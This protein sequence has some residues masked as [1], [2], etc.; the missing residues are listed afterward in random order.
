[1]NTFDFCQICDC[2]PAEGQVGLLHQEE[3]LQVST[4][5]INVSILCVLHWEFTTKSLCPNITALILKFCSIQAAWMQFL[6]ICFFSRQFFHSFHSFQS[7]HSFHSLFFSRQFFAF[8]I[9]FCVST[10]AFTLR[11]NQVQLPWSVILMCNQEMQPTYCHF[12]HFDDFS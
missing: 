6:Q 1:M 10:V 11:H 8:A 12:R 3:L 5:V 9:Y 4:N 2:W 7:F